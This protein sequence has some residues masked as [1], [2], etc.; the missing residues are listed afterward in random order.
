[1]GDQRIET[2]EFSGRVLMVGCGSIG[3]AMLPLLRKHLVLPEDGLTE[4]EA[5]GPDIADPVL[6]EALR[7]AFGGGALGQVPWILWWLAVAAARAG[8]PERAA[9]LAGA[10]DRSLRESGK[11]LDDRGAELV[12]E[13]VKL[14]RAQLDDRRVEEARAEGAAMPV[15]EL[16]ADVLQRFD[17]SAEARA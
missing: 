6:G 15:D 1:M 9:R 14:V 4:L 2:A 12:E 5:S 7:V 11:E 13:G 16:V 8:A 3:Q 10:A 17:L